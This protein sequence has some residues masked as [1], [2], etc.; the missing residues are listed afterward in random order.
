MTPGKPPNS[1]ELRPH[2]VNECYD[3]VIITI[4]LDKK[5]STSFL[6]QISNFRLGFCI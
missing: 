3:G 2:E 1:C 4:F 5:K 6:L